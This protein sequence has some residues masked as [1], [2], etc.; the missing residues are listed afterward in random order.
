MNPGQIDHVE[1][2]LNMVPENLRAPRVQAYLGV[3]LQQIDAV[4][5]LVQTVLDAIVN[6]QTAGAQFDWVLDLIGALLQQSRPDGFSDAQY[7]FIL[8]ARVLVRRS[9]ATRDDVRLVVSFLAR[10]NPASVVSVAPKIL[11][12][13][14]VDLILSAQEQ[15][16]YEQL[17][18]GAIDAV[19]QLSVQYI[20]SSSAFYDVDL[21]DVGL[22]AP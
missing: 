21:Y 7:T 16:I 17:L 9:T 19:D 11:I 3:Y 14:F 12:V 22:Y 13:T 1:V 10:G 4:E 15:A 8:Q 18:L 2:G 20:T 5:Q 6:W